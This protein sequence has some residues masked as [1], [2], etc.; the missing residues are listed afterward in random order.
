MN[1]RMTKLLIVQAL[2]ITA[3]IAAGCAASQGKSPVPSA[4]ERAA[5]RGEPPP[6]TLPAAQQRPPLFLFAGREALYLN[7]EPLLQRHDREWDSGK[8]DTLERRLRALSKQRVTV[9]GHG[10]T[11]V[12]VLWQVLSTC[13][14]AGFRDV[15]LK[16]RPPGVLLKPDRRVSSEECRALKM[17]PA[18]APR[19]DRNIDILIGEDGYTLTH[20]TGEKDFPV[21]RIVIAKDS[22]RFLRKK[23]LAQVI[24]WKKRDET[25]RILAEAGAPLAEVAAVLDMCRGLKYR[26]LELV[27]VE[28]TLT[29]PLSKKRG[30]PAKKAAP[31]L[32][33][34]PRPGVVLGKTALRGGLDHDV[35]RLILARHVN[36][37]KFCYVR[38]LKTS[39][40]LAGELRVQ[41]TVSSTGQVAAVSVLSSTT[42]SARLDLCIVGAFRRWLF[43]RPTGGGIAVITVPVTLGTA[44]PGGA[45]AP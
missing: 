1:Q 40:R 39:P 44:R 30:A 13:R 6:A 21:E 31:A 16:L 36:E 24:E 18:K 2:G 33:P 3:T 37:V 5:R 22:G 9:C 20:D 26:R 7:Q 42:K 15:T 38:Q 4:S 19:G 41:F 25:A 23:L 43:P 45:L 14:G 8:L 10:E 28:E 12:G 32:P 29:Y 17:P 35:V 27:D 34:A 11:T